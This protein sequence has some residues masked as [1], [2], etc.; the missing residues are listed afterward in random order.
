MAYNQ[1]DKQLMRLD[2]QL[3]AGTADRLTDAQHAQIE[4]AVLKRM[5]QIDAAP[6]RPVAKRQSWR[7]AAIGIAAAAMVLLAAGVFFKPE[8]KPE[9]QPLDFAALAQV[10]EGSD[11]L[12]QQIPQWTQ[13]PEQAMQTEITRLSND[14]Q[15]AVA[16]LL[17]CA[18][19]NPLPQMD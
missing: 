19:G 18:P 12:T 13:W 17:N 10:L 3:R 8:Q 7:P 9:P 11:M 5:R 14:A 16:F 1:F 4:A 2:A 6:L 15:R